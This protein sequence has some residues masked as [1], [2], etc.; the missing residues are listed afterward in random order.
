MTVV[1]LVILAALVLYAQEPVRV[2]KFGGIVTETDPARLGLD[3]AR[4]SVGWVYRGG[5]LV[6]E[7]FD[8]QSTTVHVNYPLHF[9]GQSRSDSSVL[10]Y[11]DDIYRLRDGSQE[12]IALTS[13]TMNYDSVITHA[14]DSIVDKWEFHQQDDTGMA[15]HWLNWALTDRASLRIDGDVWPVLHFYS[16][17]W[18]LLTDTCNDSRSKA[19]EGSDL[20]TL[21]TSVGF[22]IDATAGISALE[23]TNTDADTT[24]LLDGNYLWHYANG[25]ISDAVTEEFMASSSILDTGRVG[26]VSE[27]GDSLVLNLAHGGAISPSNYVGK[28]ILWSDTLYTARAIP[29]KVLAVDSAWSPDSIQVSVLADSA[30]HAGVDHY[31]N[32]AYYMVYAPGS[33]VAV[34]ANVYID[35]T[36]ILGQY[37]NVWY[38]KMGIFCGGYFWGSDPITDIFPAPYDDDFVRATDAN[39]W[40]VIVDNVKE[41]SGCG[42]LYG[43]NYSRD[44]VWAKCI[45]YVADTADN[46]GGT[47]DHYFY[48]LLFS[49]EEILDTVWNSHITKCAQINMGNVNLYF[50]KADLYRRPLLTNWS[51]SQ[52][53]VGACAYSFGI[54]HRR[55]SWFSGD[56]AHPMRL[57]W[58]IAADF[59]DIDQDVEDLEGSDPITALSSYGQQMVA[60]RRRAG[61]YVTGFSEADFYKA[62]I[63]AGVGAVNWNTIAR[64]PEDN[65]DYFCNDLGLWSYQGGGVQQ[66]GVHAQ[67]IFSDSIEWDAEERMRAAVWDGKYWL[68][69]PHDGDTTNT[70]LVV[71]DIETG[72]VGY[73]A[74]FRV[75]SMWVYRGSDGSEKLYLGCADSSVI[76]LAGGTD[77]VYE[78][79]DWR[80]GWWDAGDR[81]ATKR[82]ASYTLDYSAATGDTIF[83]DFYVDGT[84]TAV[85]T[86]TIV[87]AADGF[88]KISAAVGRSVYGHSISYGFRSPDETVTIVGM[89]LEPVMLGKGRLK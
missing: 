42:S 39:V 54:T 50:N 45:H 6:R 65:A 57:A 8:Q 3:Q 12:D 61:E 37:G 52:T 72:D 33:R 68:A 84:D 30:M 4:K 1:A 89:A 22:S 75:A 47:W 27:D 25:G 34:A 31:Y 18:A 58:G 24:L 71:F 40:E 43:F 46:W 62:P 55:R 13:A 51:S 49:N 60:W 5:M 35:T 16:D 14:G 36:I 41:T 82:I 86:D 74:P 9:L 64:S 17:K 53:G 44:T 76:W 38:A 11:S 78:L 83:V 77:D 80:S 88:A 67:A 56:P 73:L 70:R 87:A 21:T 7:T 26:A 85:W 19:D 29:A 15:M 23:Y 48:F 69:Y 10:F 20:D 32:G 28:Y 79:A 66:I 63:P 81:G 2:E 59:D